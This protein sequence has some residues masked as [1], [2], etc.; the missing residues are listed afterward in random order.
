MGA[1]PHDGTLSRQGRSPIK[2]AY[3]PSRPETDWIGM[4]AVLATGPTVAQ[5]SPL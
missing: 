4:L 5:N 3:S 1:H 2:P